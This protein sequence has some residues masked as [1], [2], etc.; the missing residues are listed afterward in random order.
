[1]LGSATHD[2]ILEGLCVDGTV[3]NQCGGVL[4]NNQTATCIW[5]SASSAINP[6]HPIGQCM[7][8]DKMNVSC[9]VSSIEFLLPLS[10]EAFLEY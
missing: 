10:F 6:S 5:S 9:S 3:Y 1:M 2:D 8:G 7:Y 4:E